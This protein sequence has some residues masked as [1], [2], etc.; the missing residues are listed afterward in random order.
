MTCIP[1]SPLSELKSLE[2]VLDCLRC[3]RTHILIS[4]MICTPFV[5]ISWY[6]PS[7]RFIGLVHM[8][9][10]AHSDRA[11]WYAH[12]LSGLQ[13]LAGL[14]ASDV[15]DTHFD[16]A[17]WCLCALLTGFP[18][19]LSAVRK[20]FW[21]IF[22]LLLLIRIVICLIFS[23]PFYRILLSLFYRSWELRSYHFLF[24]W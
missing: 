21:S 17:C 19:C 8:C 14:F 1:F 3:V 10:N 15:C 11:I 5:C 23:T 12:P 16:H 6:S 24:P 7:C 20:V 18:Y 13:S 9:T 22:S 2:G 4:H